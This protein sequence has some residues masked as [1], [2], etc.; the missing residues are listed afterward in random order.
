MKKA[1]KRTTAARPKPISEIESQLMENI[2]PQQR[3]REIKILQWLISSLTLRQAMLTTM[4]QYE[5]GVK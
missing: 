4:A 2:T 5:E 1:K 3:E